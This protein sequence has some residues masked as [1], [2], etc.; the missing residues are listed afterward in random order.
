MKDIQN[1]NDLRK[2]AINKVGVTSVKYPITLL[3]RD[4]SSQHTICDIDLCVDL[5]HDFRGAHMSRFIEIIHNYKS[6]INI[7]AIPD[8]L[9]NVRNSLNAESAHIKITFPYFMTK[10]AP[11]S[12]ISSLMPYKVTFIGTKNSNITDIVINVE[13][14]VTTLCPCS[15]EISNH[16]AH[17]QRSFLSI[18]VRTKEFMWIEELIE[19][20]ESC[21]S[22]QIYP[23]LKRED[24]KYVTE[25]AYN[26]PRFAEDIVRE[27]V[28]K[29]KKNGKIT[30]LKVESLNLESIHPHNTYACVEMEI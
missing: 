21:A 19:I 29:L 6:S 10:S 26:N 7:D 23:L 14:P 25:H 22:S 18:S 3:D 30:W 11:I 20:A 13:I 27:A 16:G 12:H 15:K 9:E 1:E 4:S 5:P 28:L 8:I 2:I 17:N 24:E